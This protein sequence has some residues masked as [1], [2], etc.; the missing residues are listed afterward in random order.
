MPLA[1]AVALHGALLLAVLH[2]LKPQ[3]VAELVTSREVIV[4]LV[5]QHTVAPT[6]CVEHRVER[7]PEPVA[8]PILVVSPVP[9][10]ISQPIHATTPIPTPA[11]AAVQR[12]PVAEAP[13]PAHVHAAMPRHRRRQLR[14]LSQHWHPLRSSSLK[15]HWR[16]PI[17]QC[18]RRQRQSALR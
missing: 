16:T 17:R 8:R 13:A 2:G 12:T 6:T 5:P 18:H 4:S 15:P 7:Q 3:T 10:A 11:P 1:A 9:P 14:R